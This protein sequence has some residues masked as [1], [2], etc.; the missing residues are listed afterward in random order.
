MPLACERVMTCSVHAFTLFPET[1]WGDTF[2][3]GK[4]CDHN[5]RERIELKAVLVIPRKVRYQIIFRQC[6][7]RNTLRL[8]H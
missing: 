8:V 3:R 1:K 4:K 2:I 7:P 6:C 5:M